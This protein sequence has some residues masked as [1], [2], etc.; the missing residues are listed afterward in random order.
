MKT[1]RLSVLLTGLAF[2][3]S[4]ALAQQLPALSGIT[5]EDKHPNG[6]VDCHTQMG[7]QDYRLNAGLKNNPEHPD[8][9]EVTDIVPES[10]KMCHQDGVEA[11]AMNLI[12]HK[13]HYHKPP[14]ENH[15][16]KYYQGECLSC[17]QLNSSTGQMTVKNGPKNW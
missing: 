9:D 7:D 17:H 2:F 10:C 1:I 13:V 6:C 15:F 5:I 11:G 8:I 3:C 12:S 4:A 14:A 16:I